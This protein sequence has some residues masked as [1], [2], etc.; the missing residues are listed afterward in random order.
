[1]AWIFPQIRFAFNP[2]SSR[3]QARG[4]YAAST[5][6][7]AERQNGFDGRSLFEK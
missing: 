5:R 6:K 7:G 3:F 1:M 2:H 4:I